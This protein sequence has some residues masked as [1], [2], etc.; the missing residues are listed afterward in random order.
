MNEFL[1]VEFH[2][3][4]MYSDDSFSRLEDMIFEAKKKGVDRLIIT[5]HH[6]IEGAQI[7]EKMAPD[8]VI[9]GEEI[10]TD[11]GE[12]LAAYVKVNIPDGTPYRKAIEMLR[13]QD[14]FISVSHPFDV[15][16]SGWTTTELV[17]LAGLVDAF[18]VFN[19]RVY[20]PSEN[21]NA[22]AFAQEHNKPGTVGSDAHMVREI[23]VATLKLPYFSNGNELRKVI[24]AG[25]PLVKLSPTWVHYYSGFAQTFKK[26]VR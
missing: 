4:S 18:E 12:L 1:N 20:H 22:L 8:V 6:T 10:Q 21:M 23:G 15:K 14:A 13:E 2:C 5:D 7:A 19:A 11:K 25:E 16:R 3:H 24:N 17:E 9:V 26:L